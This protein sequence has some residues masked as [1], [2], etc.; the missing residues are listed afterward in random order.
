MVR[1]LLRFAVGACLAALVSA[2]AV[3]E[4]PAGIGFAQ[5]EE[6]TWWCLDPK[7]GAAVGCGVMVAACVGRTWNRAA[8]APPAIVNVT[9]AAPPA[10]ATGKSTAGS[11]PFAAT[12]TG[13]VR[14]DVLATWSATIGTGCRLPGS[15][16]RCMGSLI[17]C[18]IAASGATNAAATT[19]TREILRR[20]CMTDPPRR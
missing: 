7:F 16:S 3:A 17:G 15:L 12:S 13:T 2:P 19:T 8:A 10:V 4:G 20:R 11:E 18:V 1:A 9:G 14:V 6:G 5:A